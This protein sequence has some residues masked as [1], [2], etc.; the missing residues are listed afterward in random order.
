MRVVVYDGDQQAWSS[1]D[2]I[3]PKDPQAVIN[4]IANALGDVRGSIGFVDAPIV[5]AKDIIDDEKIALLQ[6]AG[7]EIIP[8]EREKIEVVVEAVVA[9]RI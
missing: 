5:A 4:V 1:D 2:K 3:A 7:Y 9:E 6:A 8:R